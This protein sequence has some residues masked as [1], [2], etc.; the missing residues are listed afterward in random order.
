M[1]SCRAFKTE[2]GGL[3]PHLPHTES[4]VIQLHVAG[5]VLK[6]FVRLRLPL[7]WVGL[8]GKKRKS[9]EGGGGE[10]EQLPLVYRSALREPAACALWAGSSHLGPQRSLPSESL[11]SLHCPEPGMCGVLKSQCEMN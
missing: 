4:E 10:K 7:W 1:S 2:I 5:I 9:L 11:N 8:N 3:F 6:E